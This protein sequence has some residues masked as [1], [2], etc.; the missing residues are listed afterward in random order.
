[1][2][3][4]AAGVGLTLC[5]VHHRWPSQL[6]DPLLG[7]PPRPAPPRPQHCWQPVP[8]AS[9]WR[10]LCDRDAVLRYVVH[11]GEAPA[12]ALAAHA[13]GFD[14]RRR[15]LTLLLRS[16]VALRLS[17]SAHLVA[18]L[19]SAL[20]QYAPSAGDFRVVVAEKARRTAGRNGAPER[21]W[22]LR[23]P[24]PLRVLPH[25]FSSNASVDWADARPGDHAPALVGFR[26][27]AADVAGFVFQ[28]PPAGASP[29]AWLRNLL[30]RPESCEGPQPRSP[31]ALWTP[32][33]HLH[34][35][36]RAFVAAVQ[37]ALHA[38]QLRAL[39]QL[40]L[41]LIMHFASEPRH[42]ASREWERTRRDWAAQMEDEATWHDI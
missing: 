6:D 27:D 10:E 22:A 7:A 12:E 17:V 15:R 30:Y 13:A 34:I 32:Q 18:T 23:L 4:R 21:G 14:A 19:R 29:A 26:V 35:C 40:P 3:A 41:A 31:W 38:P 20:P 11:G 1:M 36:S 28:G 33:A 9:H 25:Q 39:P 16:A 24:A 37:A 42:A 8:A 2:L 5:R